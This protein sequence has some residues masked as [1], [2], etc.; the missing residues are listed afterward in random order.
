MVGFRRKDKRMAGR[1]EGVPLGADSL[2][3]LEKPN[4][5]KVPDQ[6]C[7]VGQCKRQAQAELVK[8][9]FEGAHS[10]DDQMARLKEL[11]K[12]RGV[13]KDKPPSR[14]QA[15]PQKKKPLK[16][17]L[18]SALAGINMEDPGMEEWNRSTS[19]N[20]SLSGRST[21]MPL[22]DVPDCASSTCPS[23]TISENGS[24]R[25]ESEVFDSGAEPMKIS[26][27]ATCFG[28]PPPG[29]GYPPPG[30]QRMQ[31]PMPLYVEP[32]LGGRCTF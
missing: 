23:E 10:A 27:A 30:L 22:G 17:S 6:H 19:K 16:L 29:L 31:G 28:C 5:R 3:T 2:V 21:C 11:V 18:S 1:I 14:Q 26:L 24:T 7:S 15:H 13:Q 12:V 8:T 32:G 25:D 9:T 20:S 4:I